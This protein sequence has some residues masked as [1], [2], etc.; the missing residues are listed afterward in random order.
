MVHD[1]PAMSGYGEKRTGI[2]GGFLQFLFPVYKKRF[3]VLQQNTL[4]KFEDENS[5]N[6]L[7]NAFVLDELTTEDIALGN[8]YNKNF[9][10]ISFTLNIRIRG[11]VKKNILIKLESPEELKEWLD[12]LN[13]ICDENAKLKESAPSNRVVV[14]KSDEELIKEE[15][16]RRQEEFIKVQK[17]AAAEERRQKQEAEQALDPEQLRKLQEQ[18]A[19]TRNHEADKTKHYGKRGGAF[20]RGNAL[21]GG[22]RGGAGRGRRESA[23]P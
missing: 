11:V 6:T 3:F 9:D 18:Q 22:G 4:Y 5:I 19:E 10:D 14:P 16:E 23:A 7:G 13:D 8:P 1:G 21:T 20:V 12:K 17:A 15:Q 2:F